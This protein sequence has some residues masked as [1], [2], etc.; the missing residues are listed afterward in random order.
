MDYFRPAT[1]KEGIFNKISKKYFPYYPRIIT[2]GENGR[3]L[4]M[5]L[6][7]N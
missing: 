7:L 5:I 1:K 6:S 4:R 3:D 2:N